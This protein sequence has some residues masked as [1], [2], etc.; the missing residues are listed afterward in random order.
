METGLRLKVSYDRLVKPGMEPATPGLQGKRFIHYTTAAPTSTIQQCNFRI[1]QY[2]FEILV[3]IGKQPWLMRASPTHKIKDQ[4]LHMQSH[5][6]ATHTSLNRTLMHV[7][8][9]FN[10]MGRRDIKMRGMPSI[11][12]FFA[13]SFNKFNNTGA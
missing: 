11:N 13:M 12:H 4:N 3:L 8:I 5:C 7:R 2:N 1:S 9:L 6:V 10:K